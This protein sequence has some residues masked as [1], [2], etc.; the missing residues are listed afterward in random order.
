MKTSTK[1]KNDPNDHN[2]HT[3]H[4]MTFTRCSFG[5]S[6][7]C[8]QRMW[9]A[10]SIS[11]SKPM[12]LVHFVSIMTIAISVSHLRNHNHH[13]VTSVSRRAALKLHKQTKCCFAVWDCCDATR[14]FYSLQKSL[15]GHNH[16][17][18][19]LRP[20]QIDAGGDSGFG[21]THVDCLILHL[22]VFVENDNLSTVSEQNLNIST[23]NALLPFIKI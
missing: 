16:G 13:E 6:S 15:I 21:S 14:E 9:V 23:A 22:A 18:N 12:H 19:Q 3:L 1:T 10:M 17:P 5:R 11:S 4:R 20:M 2:N 8:L 7:K